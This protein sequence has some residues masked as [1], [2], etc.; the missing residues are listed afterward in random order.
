MNQDQYMA[1][2]RHGLT[3]IGGILAAQGKISQGDIEPL[4]GLAMV[5]VSLAWSL[6]I[7]RTSDAGNRMPDAGCSGPSTMP[8]QPFSPQC[9]TIGDLPAE[10]PEAIKAASAGDLQI[11]TGCGAISTVYG[12]GGQEKAETGDR[13]PEEKAQ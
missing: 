2:I 11:S 3:A 8:H 7:K 5:L 13:K 10:N 6:W 4:V 9:P 1:A 12:D